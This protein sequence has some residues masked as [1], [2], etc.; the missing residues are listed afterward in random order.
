[1]KK[2]NKETK[3]TS[4][5]KKIIPALAMLTTSAL[6]LSS[7]TYAWFTLNKEVEVTGL[8][9]QATAGQS[10]EISLGAL[11]LNADNEIVNSQGTPGKNDISW[12][13]SIAVGDYYSKVG[14]L[15]PVSSNKATTLYKVDE[16]NIYAGGREVEES[17]GVEAASGTDTT[18]LILRET[19]TAENNVLATDNDHSGYYVDIPMWIRTSVTKEGGTDVDCTVTIR[20]PNGDNGS[21]LVNAVRVAVIPVAASNNME[22]INSLALTGTHEESPA[23]AETGTL[24]IYGSSGTQIETKTGEVPN[25]ENSGIGT[26]IFGL[27][28]VVY[29]YGNVISGVGENKNTYGTCDKGTATIIKAATDEDVAKTPVHT[30]FNLQSATKDDYSVEAF[31]VRIW[32]EGESIYCNDAT[33]DQDWDID[34]HFAICEDGT[35]TNG[36]GTGEKADDFDNDYNALA[37]NSTIYVKQT[38]EEP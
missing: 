9:M 29:R 23:N 25:V 27:S 33:A 31:I 36:N 20:D 10:L 1:M 32:I 30:V 15:K 34:L 11:S 12:K 19:R 21:N 17:A 37:E 26:T 24:A 35:H 3:N 7:T 2:N 6:M 5:R 28:S 16:D 38:P 18:S 4:A 13:R 22:S 14:L 8:Q